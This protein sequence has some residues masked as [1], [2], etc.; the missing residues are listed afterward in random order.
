[1]FTNI[2]KKFRRITTNQLY[3]PEID[4]IRF[5][6][7]MLVILFHTHGYFMGKST[8]AFADD[9]GGYHL[10]NTFLINGDRGVELF[11]VLSGFILCLPFAHHYINNGKKVLLKKYY[12][13]RVTR[14]EP[15]YFIAMTVIF[16]MQ[17]AMHIKPISVLLP[18]WLASLAYSH[19]LIYH[20]TPMLTV[21]AWSL[22]IEIQFYLLA[23]LLFRLLALNKLTRRSIL[24]AA[25]V[26]IIFAQ[27]RYTPP[28]LSIYGFAQYFFIGILLADLYVS[29]AAAAFF[30]K[31]WIAPLAAFCLIII[32]YFPIKDETLPSGTL[33]LIRLCFPF[34]LCVFY[35]TVFKNDILKRAFSYK[36]IPII[37]GMCYSIYLLHYTII[38]MLGRFTLRLH[39]TSY[40]L[41]NLF[42][43]IV[44]MCIP[45]L[46]ISS[47]FY[48][49]IERPFMSKKWVD[50]LMK[51]D[52]HDDVANMEGNLP[53][54]Q[55]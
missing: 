45:I 55:W 43:Q 49:Y 9:P 44:L 37:G 46:I 15:P 32:I 42:L 34:L 6:A 12:L 17:V 27:W 50:K 24:I 51:K 39:I 22:E 21:V 33:F 26:A 31:K 13:R 8:M 1:M 2:Y 52:K 28:F 11:F 20:Q 36:F 38:S 48:F 23:P 53:G 30:N 35:Y 4:G 14:L 10:L 47:I 5:L 3:F 18:H 54:R 25:T 41:P 40:Y 16:L 7:I 19:D 29:D